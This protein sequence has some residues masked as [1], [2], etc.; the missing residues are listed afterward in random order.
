MTAASLYFC[1]VSTATST[2]AAWRMH[3]HAA[4]SPSHLNP[5][6]A[7]SSNSSRSG[8]FSPTRQKSRF[9]RFFQRLSGDLHARAKILEQPGQHLAVVDPR[10][11]QAD[12]MLSRPPMDFTLATSPAKWLNKSDLPMFVRRRSHHE[13]L[14]FQLRTQLVLSNLNHSSSPAAD[15]DP[16]GHRHQGLSPRRVVDL[17]S[18]ASEIDGH[19]VELET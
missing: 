6:P 2:S 19:G 3:G 14:A 1:W 11:N 17:G 9:S 8:T 7:A 5:H 10:W 15:L 13:R 4:S 12:R 16:S 18:P